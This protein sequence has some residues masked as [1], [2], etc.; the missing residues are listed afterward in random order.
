MIRRPPSSTLLPYTALF[1]SGGV[2]KGTDTT[3]PYA[4]SWPI[5]SSVNGAHSWTAR[6]YDAANNTTTSTAVGLT[7]SIPAADTIPRTVALSTPP[8][9]PTYPAARP[10]LLTP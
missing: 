8:P 1:R 3:S 10:V 4:Y 5:T 7:V 2:L 9:S 6:A